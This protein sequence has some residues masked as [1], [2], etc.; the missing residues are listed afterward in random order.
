ML[1]VFEVFCDVCFVSFVLLCF[2][3]SF[4]LSYFRFFFLCFVRLRPVSVYHIFLVAL[5]CSFLIV[6]FFSNVYLIKM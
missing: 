6:P 1:L 3:F 5:D 2:G 4:A